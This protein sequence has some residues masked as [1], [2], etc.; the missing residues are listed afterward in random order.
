MNPSR[1]IW[2]IVVSSLYSK[3]GSSPPS[4]HNTV[5]L[6]SLEGDFLLFSGLTINLNLGEE[7]DGRGGRREQGE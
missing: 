4:T 5:V 6:I 7:S 2:C 3:K 1:V